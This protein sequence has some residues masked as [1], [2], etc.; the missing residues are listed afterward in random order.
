MN[1]PEV[2]VLNHNRSNTYMAF[3]FSYLNKAQICK[4]PYRVSPHHEFQIIFVFKY[5]NLCKPTEHTEDDQIRKPKDEIFLF[6][7]EDKK[8]IFVEDTV[9]TSETIVKIVNSSPELGF[10]DIKFPFGY[11]EE[12]NYFMFHQKYLPIQE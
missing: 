11:G 10:N 7:N 8:S 4:I 9:V 1:N 12:N 5:L 3:V 2:Y 6:Q